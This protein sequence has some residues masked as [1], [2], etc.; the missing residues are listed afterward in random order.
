MQLPEKAEIL[1]EVI[2]GRRSIRDYEPRDIPDELLEKIVEAGIWAP[3][4]SNLQPREFILVRDKK[5]IEAIKMVSPG[6]FGD[7]AAILVLCYNREIA[8]KGG[9][10][11]ELMAVMD[12]AMAAQNM[13]LMAYALG[14]GSCPVLS[15]NKQALKILLDIPDHIEPVLMLT[16]GYPREKP[17]PPKRRSVKEVLH[18]DKY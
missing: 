13:M 12:T 11:G 1:M 17:E 18:V 3:S 15:F 9:R 8:R 4:G 7:P 5:L 10:M 14:L 16:L 2:K 6:L